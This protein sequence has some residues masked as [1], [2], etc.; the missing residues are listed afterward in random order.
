MSDPSTTELRVAFW[1]TWLLA[2]RFWPGGPRV[3][4]LAGKVAPEVDRRAPLVADAV[5]GR[6]DVV[7]LAE[8]WDPAEQRAISDR[9]PEAAAVGGVEGRAV[10]TG[11]GLLTLVGPGVDLVR[12][13]R[14][15]YRSS[16]DL[17]D[18]DHLARK[19]ALLT[20]VGLGPDL[21]P[22][23]IVS[24]HLFAGGDLLPRAG[25]DDHDR[26]H[27]VR[28]EQVDELI[29]FVER[30]HDPA[31]P[32]LVVGDVNV[33]AWDRDADAHTAAYR[34][35][36]DHLGRAG[37]VDLWATH[38]IGQGPTASFGPDDDLPPDP[39]EPDRVADLI[40]DPEPSGGDRIDH[41]WLSVPDGV[42][43][44]VE[45]PR[46]W[47]FAG[48]GVTGGPAGSLSDHLAVSTTLRFGPSADES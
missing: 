24:T 20:V 1:N 22:V 4:G 45:R 43:V 25:H 39:E 37:L 12:S 3:P 26:H 18:A 41:L 15:R 16:G 27:L 2:P 11:S 6:F 31:S 40:D 5:A 7:A 34:D 48:R 13:A 36:A 8:V 38:G 14:H 32:L 30:E 23:E 33:A 44:E 19:G 28:M 47:A 21:P 29:G 46:R 10:R 42:A 17:R 35:L 9:W